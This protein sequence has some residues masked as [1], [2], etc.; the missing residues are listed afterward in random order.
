ME[1]KLRAGKYMFPAEMWEEKDRIFLKFGFNRTLLEEVKAME[2]PKWHGYDEKPRKLWSVKKSHRN[3]FQLDYLMGKNPYAKYDLPLVEYTSKRPLYD[4]QIEMVRHCLTR[5]S[6]VLAAE[7]GTGKTLVAIEVIEQFPDKEWFWVGPKPAL[8]AAHEQ[9]A[10]WKSPAKPKFLT[11]EGLTKLMDEWTPG[12]K[13]PFGV[14]FDESSRL[15]NP[16]SQ[17]S[18][19]A[20]ALAEGIREDHEDG[21]VIEMSGS[22]AP[23]SPADWWHQ[24]EV[25]CPGFLR[26]GT[27]MKFKQRMAVIVNREGLTGGS[28]PHLVTWRDSETKCQT[29]GEVKE[30]VAH[31]A[32]A[33]VFN[34]TFHS[35]VPGANEVVKL[36]ERMK[37]LV[38]VK[39]KK[40]C[41]N[42][43]EKVYVTLRAAPSRSTLNAAKLLTAKSVNAAQALIA[44]RELS[45]GFQYKEVPS[46]EKGCDNCGHTG[47]TKEKYDPQN[48]E[49]A[50]SNEAIE[51]GRV[52]EREAICPA[53]SGSGKVAL[54]TREAKQIPC[55]KE[56]LLRE[57]LAKQEDIGRIVIYAG[58]TGSVDRCVSICKDEG[59]STIR[60]DGRGW[61]GSS[62]LPPGDEALYHLF[63]KELGK[64]PKVAF[65]GQPGAAGM[66]LT[67]TAASTIVYYSNDFNAESKIQSED[68]IH[69]AGM[70]AER[71]ATIVELIH[72]PTDEKVIENL[73]KKRQLQDMSMGEVQLMLANVETDEDRK[74]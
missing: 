21:F 57:V 56:D 9:F 24:C 29:C 39:F 50:L 33:A 58:F 67:L 69:R 19:A 17:R 26:E 37:G 5:R 14:I 31:D 70:N 38:L 74:F 51:A 18:Q 30:H 36:Y 22:P 60:V 45:D 10:H 63:Q 52:A 71:G 42:L 65:I 15:K 72:L 20:L 49:E 28:Y 13:A 6:V 34:E 3:L 55:P 23:K 25:A 4:H 44:L 64:Y 61:S 54:Y 73:R 11:Y 53:C 66:G 41:L 35:F 8:R 1:I 68:R 2:G 46:G 27:F 59:W 12:K 43:P 40:D 16:T 47:Q 62:D 48:P 7:M 32:G